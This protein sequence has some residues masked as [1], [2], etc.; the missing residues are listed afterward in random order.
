MYASQAVRDKLANYLGV[1]AILGS[2][3]GVTW[4]EPEMAEFVPLTAG[5]G[6]TSRVLYRAIELPGSPPRFAPAMSSKRSHSVAYEF[7]DPESRRRL[8]V[9]PDVGALNSGLLEAMAGCD[10]ILFDGTFWSAEELSTAKANAPT[11]TEM[12]H[13]P[14]KDGS[15]EVLGKS[16]ARTKIYVH[17]NNTNPMLMPNSPEREAVEAA[18]IVVGVDGMEFEL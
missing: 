2:F 14:I 8:L 13:I 1:E 3:C 5:P 15:L 6:G 4:H 10:A 16:G 17:I 7:K 18:G 11:A 12:G 9:A